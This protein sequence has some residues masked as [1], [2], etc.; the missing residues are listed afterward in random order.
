M[1]L[2]GR[3]PVRITVTPSTA[4]QEAMAASLQAHIDELVQKNRTCEHNIRR[5]QQALQDE[6]ERGIDAVT[7]LKAVSLQEREEW[8]EGCDSLLASHRIVHLRTRNELDKEKLNVLREKED[9]RR[10]RIAVLHRDYKL[11]LFQAKEGDLEARIADYEDA[12]EELAEQNDELTRQNEEDAKE[13]EAQYNETVTVLTTNLKEA[14]ALRKETAGLV[15]ALRAENATL[16]SDL[17][18]LRGESTTLK[19][20]FES[21]STKLER[22]TLQLEGARTHAADLDTTNK[23]LIRTNADLKRQLDKW[24]TLETRGGT[25]MEEMRKRRIELEVQVREL[26]ERVKEFEKAEKESTKTLEKELKRVEKLRKENDRMAEV[27]EEA[28]NIAAKAQAE[29][30]EAQDKLSK[31]RK[32]IEKLQSANLANKRHR[33][34]AKAAHEIELPA[35]DLESEIPAASEREVEDVVT[36]VAKSRSRAKLA[37]H[38]QR[39][40]D[41]EDSAHELIE[42]VPHHGMPRVRPKPAR[43]RPQRAADADESV[44]ER[45]EEEAL[46]VEESTEK[47]AYS[48][49]DGARKRKNKSPDVSERDQEYHEEQFK[50]Q[51]D[52]LPKKTKGTS[53]ENVVVAASDVEEESKTKGKSKSRGREKASATDDEEAPKVRSVRNATSASIKPT[54]QPKGRKPSSNK[55]GRKDAEN[56]G[57]ENVQQP[58]KKKKRLFP[59]SQPMTFPW[60]DLPKASESVLVPECL[61]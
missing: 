34:E 17:L 50:E 5:L 39:A 13:F 46:H 18:K 35:S 48:R 37:Y 32:L 53:K 55:G 8:R 12:L 52:I 28:Q 26:Q 60:D 9:N 19:A 54:G 22:T 38:E 25:E 47:R 59:P 2:V 11:T 29:S 36:P 57:E 33:K 42:E 31:A 41:V 1:A 44:D 21:S 10:E 61:H 58:K 20:S 51:S 27:T 6:K 15:K 4:P 14:Y 45:D 30:D 56:S 40:E 23:E 16:Q 3:S 49:T 7:R 43:R 24:E